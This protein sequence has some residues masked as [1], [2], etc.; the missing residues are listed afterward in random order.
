MSV[1]DAIVYCKNWI[2]HRKWLKANNIDFSTYKEEIEFN[3][4]CN[5]FQFEKRANRVEFSKSIK[6]VAQ[7]LAQVEIE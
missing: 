2:Y 5:R 6:F 4:F 3:K 1:N 7:K